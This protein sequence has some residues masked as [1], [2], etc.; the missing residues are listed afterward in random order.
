[1][2]QYRS[3]GQN[4]FARNAVRFQSSGVQGLSRYIGSF[5][6]IT[7]FFG[8]RPGGLSALACRHA[9][10]ISGS[11]KASIPDANVSRWSSM[12]SDLLLRGAESD[13][14]RRER[15]CPQIYRS[16]KS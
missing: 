14:L 2:E 13:D 5:L 4:R 10:P 12:N 7:Y 6:N 16:L 11:N 9:N 1:Q 8:G 15:R 3:Q